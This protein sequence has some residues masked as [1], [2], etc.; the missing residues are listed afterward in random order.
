MIKLS[1]PSIPESAIEK[2]AE[3]LRSGYLIHGPECEAFEEE[4]THYT[5]AK[6]ALVVSNGT[7]ALHIA[8]LA[9][10]IT[11]GDAVLVPDFTFAATANV[12][13]MVGAKAIIV[14]VENYSYNMCP[15]LLKEKIQNWQGPETLKAIMPVLEFGNPSNLL[16]YREIADEYNLLLIEDAACALGA[17]IK[18][19][20]VGTI[21][22]IG[23]FSFHPRKT[24]TTGEGG[25]LITD[26][27]KLYEKAKLLR[28]HG[29]VRDPFSTKFECIGLNYRLT[30]F[31]GVIGRALLPLIDGWIK[32]RRELS[33]ELESQ[34]QP[35]VEKDA[36]ALP[37]ITEGHSLQT[38]M[39]VLNDRFDR[40]EI[41]KQLRD[42]GIETSLGA[43]SMKALALYDHS[44]NLKLSHTIGEKLY[45]HGLAIPLHEH[46]N[47]SDIDFITKSII[48]V[49]NG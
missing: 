11:I 32:K 18:D 17:K 21:G 14:D 25:A 41:I 29:M 24:L 2:V 35:L 15:R 4:L 43:Q 40:T 22:D 9:T 44:E 34:L 12:V 49:L 23:C 30:N 31:Q 6:H 37:A 39:I 16:A 42:K 33:K 45:T 13:E 20:M 1:Q 8:L 28:S 19:K 26:D 38:Y 48:E 47:L 36:I 46:L 27:S 7:A 3:I 10:G 5:G